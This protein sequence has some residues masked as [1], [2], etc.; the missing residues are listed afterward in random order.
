MTQPDSLSFGTAIPDDF[1]AISQFAAEAEGLGF[2]R[3]SM[4]EH[5]MDG[6]PPRPTV[7]SVTA[8]AAAA[9]A[10]RSIRLLTGIVLIPL[11]PPVLL[12]KLVA[13]LDVISGGRLDFGIGIGGQRNTRVEFDAVGVPVEERGRRANEMLELLPRLWTEDR[14]SFEGR[15]YRCEGVT[16]RP[17]P[18]QQPYPPVWVAGREDAAMDRAIRHGHGW[19][20]Y[21]YTVRRLRASVDKISKRAAEARRDMS[22]FHW[23]LLQPTCIADTKEEA[24]A[25]AAASIG[26][27][28]ATPTRSAEDIAQA[29]C[30]TGTS[31]DCIREVEKR[32]EAGARDIVFSWVAPEPGDAWRQM[33]QAAEE[34][35]PHFR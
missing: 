7:L 27:R 1:G 11:Y 16:L 12:A 6:D 18:V 4:G 15:Y 22:G 14:V 13:S 9:G 21:L 10:T 32:V 8:M 2:D 3:L 30:I 19:Y 17:R 25:M 20:P 23:G 34:V 33:K 24:L 35:L 31:Q 28:Y 5:I 26:R 29:L